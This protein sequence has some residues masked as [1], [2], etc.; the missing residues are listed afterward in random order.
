MFVMISGFLDD[1]KYFNNFIVDTNTYESIKN[2]L[3]NK[4][5]GDFE[6]KFEGYDL[7]FDKED[8]RFYYSLIEDSKFSHNPEVKVSNNYKIAIDNKQITD[9]LIKNNE[10]INFIIY[11]DNNYCEYNLTCTNLPLMNINY[12]GIEF[13]FDDQPMT[14]MLFDNR[15]GVINRII[16]SIGNV[17][18]RGHMTSKYPKQGLR[19][20]LLE[21]DWWTE[22]DEELLGLR[23][24]GDWILYAGYNDVDKVR[25]VFATKLW[26]ISG[27]T[28]NISE[29]NTGTEFKY[30]EL[31]IN[32]CYYGLYALGYP[33]DKKQLNLK[34]KDGLYQPR[35]HQVEENIT[36]DN[37]DQIVENI[38]IKNGYD[39]NAFINYYEKLF[40][41]Y[42]NN[43]TNSIKKII[44]E[45]EVIDFYIFNNIVQG[46]DNAYDTIKNIKICIKEINGQNKCLYIPWDLD[47]S[48]GNV[49]N[50]DNKDLTDDYAIDH[51]Y[52]TNHISNPIHMLIKLGD[53]QTEDRLI[54]RYKELRS[55]QFSNKNIISIIDKYENDI[56]GSGAYFRDMKRWPDG[57][58]VDGDYNLNR[59]KDY[60]IKRFEY[61]DSYYEE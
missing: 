40:N 38:E 31:F 58:Y 8:N 54:N 6:I 20:K 37:Y 43:D 2:K 53:K 24:D 55:K 42:K 19:L 46:G 50:I 52:N 27:A 25:N 56:Y 16:K 9:N 21:N 29:A 59:F 51:T 7:F 5:L 47:L 33:I 36:Y 45:E 23:Y 34:E 18:M 60:V 32:D 3:S 61:L 30:L 13:Y 15:K 4:E 12:E 41:F 57:S 35:N 14:M 10:N 49:Y 28:N 17:R 44:D 39:Y 22:R 26:N 48:F 11:N 1:R